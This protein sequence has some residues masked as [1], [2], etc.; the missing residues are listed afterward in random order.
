MPV[1]GA[2]FNVQQDRVLAGSG[3]TPHTLLFFEP[4]IDSPPAHSDTVMTTLVYSRDSECLWYAIHPRLSRPPTVSD[5]MPSAIERPSALDRPHTSPKHNAHSRERKRRG[6]AKAIR[7][8]PNSL[9][10]CREAIHHNTT[11]KSML[12]DIL[13]GY[14]LQDNIHLVNK[15][16]CIVT[17]DEADI[18]LCSYMMRQT[19]PRQSASS[20][21]TRT[22]SS[23]WCTSHRGCGS[24]PTSK[25]RSGMAMSW[26]SVKP[27]SR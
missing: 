12:N 5:R 3:N 2:G 18:T 17:H 15:L 1:E 22:Y 16:E 10:P 14:P 9:L 7:L 25:W 26:T 11:N 13:Y 6:I 8:T 24:L 27:L 23:F 4:M 19:E 20:V 21:T